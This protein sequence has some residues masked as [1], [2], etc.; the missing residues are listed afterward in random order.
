MLFTFRLRKKLEHAFWCPSYLICCVSMPAELCLQHFPSSARRSPFVSDNSAFRQ[1]RLLSISSL[2]SY[3]ISTKNKA[4]SFI[5]RGHAGGE[6]LLRWYFS[7]I[8][9]NLFHFSKA[10]DAALQSAPGSAAPATIVG[11]EEVGGAN[12]AAER[13]RPAGFGNRR[14]ERER[15]N[16]P[17]GFD[18]LCVFPKP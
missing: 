6:N 10:V 12:A 14:G 8:L 15:R 13:F 17:V 7:N 1:A 18:S 9:F 5:I 4:V 3:C 11:E 16:R 2:R